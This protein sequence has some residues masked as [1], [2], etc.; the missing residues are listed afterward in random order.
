MK[1]CPKYD[2]KHGKVMYRGTSVG[3][4]ATLICQNGHVLEGSP[5]RTCLKNETW[6][7][8]DSKCGEFVG[9]L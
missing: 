3:S 6:S 9:V 2:V 7:Y 8:S 1:S 5:Y 4:I